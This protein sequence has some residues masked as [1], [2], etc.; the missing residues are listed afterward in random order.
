MSLKQRL[1]RRC[2]FSRIQSSARRAKSARMGP[3]TIAIT[4]IQSNHVVGAKG[5]RILA[6]GNLGA[7]ASAFV[8]LRVRGGDR[9][10]RPLVF[11]RLLV[12]DFR[13]E[14]H[15]VGEILRP[16]YGPLVQD[17]MTASDHGHAQAFDVDLSPML[18]G[19]VEVNAVD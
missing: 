6:R 15:D 9:S 5:N 17:E 16:S 11:A 12:R 18:P 4:V 2:L 7:A 13:L 19:V 1:T 8:R 3:R 14:P 10:Q